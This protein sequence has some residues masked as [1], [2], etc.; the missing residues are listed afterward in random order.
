[1]QIL[2]GARA[3]RALA[4][5]D[6]E[7][8]P[9]AARTRGLSDRLGLDLDAVLRAFDHIPL[10]LNGDRHAAQRAVV[11]RLVS[12]GRARLTADLPGL[13]A[14]RFAGLARPGEVDLMSAAILPIV[15]DV[16]SALSG[17]D[18]P[19]DPASLLS[20]VFS[21]TMGVA[22]RRRLNGELAALWQR[23][24]AAFPD[25]PPDRIGGR[26]A[27]VVLGRDALVGTLAQALQA[28]FRAL[29]GAPLS[30]RVLDRVP[31]HTGVPYIDR[32]ARTAQPGLATGEA[33]RC[34]LTGWEAGAEADRL[35]FFGVGAHL[36]LGRALALDLFGALSD[37]LARQPGRVEVTCYRLREDDV[38]LCPD[39]FD[40][41]VLA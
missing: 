17:V 8:V 25:D 35:R 26:L 7:V 14:D 3:A 21:A 40:I 13:V 33:L 5:P 34:D 6:F 31:T 24:E 29:D 41:R 15:G 23:L 38:F 2:T 37:F 11:A 22:R 9:Y 39:R 30:N 18:C 32:I 20:R 12:E 27:L 1:M 4:S 16:V 36:C 19:A 10:C 28:H